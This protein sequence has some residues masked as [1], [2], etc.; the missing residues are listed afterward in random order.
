MP[1]SDQRR[2]GSSE[3]H[4]SRRKTG[5]ASDADGLADAAASA[6]NSTD[7]A[8]ARP[9]RDVSEATIARNARAFSESPPGETMA[10]FRREQQAPA[11]LTPN[12]AI[13]VSTTLPDADLLDRHGA[14][15]TLL[16]TVGEIL[17]A[18]DNLA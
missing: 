9:R 16:A 18:P 17:T 13:S 1:S 15:T 11:T 4:A 6:A 2:V 7:R 5:V 3:D 10:A 14:S 8:H 12:A